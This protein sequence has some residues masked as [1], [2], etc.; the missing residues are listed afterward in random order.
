MNKE[1][2]PEPDPNRKKHTNWGG[3]RPGAG[4]PKGNLNGLKHGLRSKQ[5][6]RL[7]QVWANNPELQA[8]LIALAERQGLKQNKAEDIAARVFVKLLQDFKIENQEQ[9]RALRALL[10]QLGE[11]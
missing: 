4:A 9:A 10:R 2:K 7:S 5:V 8:T 11:L 3:R 1:P 6:A